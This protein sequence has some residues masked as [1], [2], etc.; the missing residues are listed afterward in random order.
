[1]SENEEIQQQTQTSLPTTPVPENR[2]DEETQ[3][4]AVNENADAQYHQDN[5]T[6]AKPSEKE[7]NEEQ[8]GKLIPV[9]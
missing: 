2:P 1:M 7:S 8:I 9:V 5:E 3:N 4:T 6:D